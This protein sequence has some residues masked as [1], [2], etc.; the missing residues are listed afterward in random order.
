MELEGTLKSF[1]LSELLEM[2][3]QS[4]MCGVLEITGQ[5]GVGRIWAKDSLLCQAEYAGT[6]GR[7]ALWQLFAEQDAPFVVRALDSH[8]WG[9]PG[10]GRASDLIAQ[11]QE[12]IQSWQGI[13]QRIPSLDLVPLARAQAERPQ[14]SELDRIVLAALDGKRTVRDLPEITL[15][16]QVDICRALIRLID[17]GLVELRRTQAVPAQAMPQAAPQSPLPPTPVAPAA[18]I[19]PPAPPQARPGGLFKRPHGT[20]PAPPPQ[21]QG[22]LTRLQQQAANN[23]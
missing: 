13:H 1:P 7:E 15:M 21:P 19:A 4:S 11:A 14:V 12:Q 3:E 16:E 20:E 8:P 5:R 2:M 18:P 23:K 9:R 17:A 22:L 6:T 10:L